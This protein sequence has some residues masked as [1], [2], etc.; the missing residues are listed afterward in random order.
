MD[1]NGNA[2][3]LFQKNW[4]PERICTAFGISERK[5]KWNISQSHEKNRCCKTLNCRWWRFLFM[6]E[7]QERRLKL[8]SIMSICHLSSDSLNQRRRLRRWGAGTVFVF[9]IARANVVGDLTYHIV[10]AHVLFR[11]CQGKEQKQLSLVKYMDIVEPLN[12]T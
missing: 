11:Y 1:F 10:Q 5:A 2:V 4:W 9:I 6:W 12:S 8:K 7:H 3:N